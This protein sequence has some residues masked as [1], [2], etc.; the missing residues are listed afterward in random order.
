MLTHKCWTR[1]GLETRANY[2]NPVN[3][4]SFLELT[5]YKTYGTLTKWSR[6]CLWKGWKTELDETNK[7]S[8]ISWIPEK[9][10][11]GKA[12][13]TNKKC[14]K[15]LLV[16]RIEH[17]TIL[18][19]A[20]KLNFMIQRKLRKLKVSVHSYKLFKFIKHLTVMPTLMTSL[21]NNILNLFYFLCSRSCLIYWLT[22][23]WVCF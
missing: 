6:Q 3:Q 1:A 2:G 23:Y 12:S 11:I 4:V 21:L 5:V 22:T 8:K 14:G 10:E 16:K 17:A 9:I 7:T 13:E 19:W 18:K 20:E 15:A